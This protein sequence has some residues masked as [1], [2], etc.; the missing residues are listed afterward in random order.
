MD[1]AAVIMASVPLSQQEKGM[2]FWFCTE[3]AITY[4]YHKEIRVLNKKRYIKGGIFFFPQKKTKNKKDQM[5]LRLSN[6]KNS[7]MKELGC[8]IA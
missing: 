4:V 5:W 3:W 1:N 2:Q 8:F 6:N 7:K